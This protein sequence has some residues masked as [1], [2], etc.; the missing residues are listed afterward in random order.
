M[1]YQRELSLSINLPPAG[2]M[3]SAITIPLSGDYYYNF[4]SG[5]VGLT[6]L[7]LYI[8]DSIKGEVLDKASI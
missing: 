4:L 7:G 1:L 8:L 3:I 5:K 6:E 2:E